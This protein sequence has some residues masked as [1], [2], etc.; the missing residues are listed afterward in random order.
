M[1]GPSTNAIFEAIDAIFSAGYRQDGSPALVPRC[2]TITISPVE[3]PDSLF[4]PNWPI[5]AKAPVGAVSPPRS[6]K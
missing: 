1:A 5:V 3:W 4:A 6:R 2:F